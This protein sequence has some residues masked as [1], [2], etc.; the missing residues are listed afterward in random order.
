MYG[1]RLAKRGYEHIP[2]GRRQVMMI[3]LTSPHVIIFR[4]ANDST[5][6][7]A[8]SAPRSTDV[9]RSTA[10]SLVTKRATGRLIT[11]NLWAA[12][13]CSWTLDSRWVYLFVQQVT[14]DGHTCSAG[15][16]VRDCVIQ[17]TQ[18]AQE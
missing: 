9:V 6:A 5:A 7:R 14:P 15:G 12:S 11:Y 16:R 17:L 4:K 3:P 10:S 2:T 13:A 1:T 18:I 8:A